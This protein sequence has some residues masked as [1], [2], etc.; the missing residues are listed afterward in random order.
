V[1][2]TSGIQTK[3][4]KPIKKRRNTLPNVRA[5]VA[6]SMAPLVPSPGNGLVRDSVS[7]ARAPEVKE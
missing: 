4:Y 6:L 3:A 7:L 2:G 5:R 1:D